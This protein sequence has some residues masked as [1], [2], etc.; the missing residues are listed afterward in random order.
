MEISAGSLCCLSFLLA[1]SATSVDAVGPRNT[2]A[3]RGG[4]ANLTCSN[5][6]YTSPSSGAA[7]WAEGL[8]TFGTQQG[9]IYTGPAFAKYTNF[10]IVSDEFPQMDLTVSDAQ[11]ED[12]GTYTCTMITK[13]GS[14]TLAVEIEG[15]EPII[16][17]DGDSSGNPIKL[18][19][20]EQSVLRCTAS[21]FRPAVNLEWYKDDVQITAGITEDT[22]IANGYAFTTS[23]TLTFTPTKQDDGDRLECRTTGQ[24]VATAKTGGLTLNVQYAPIVNVDFRGGRI[25]CLSDANPLAAS[26]IILNGTDILV[27]FIISGGS[28]EFTPD[29]CNYISCN[30]TN[31]VG[32]GTGTFAK[33]IC[34]ALDAVGPSDT[35]VLRGD[36]ATLTCRNPAYTSPR[37]GAAQWSEGPTPF[38]TQQLGGPYTGSHFA[39]Y[40]HFGIVSVVF[41]QMDLTVSNAQIEDEGTYTCTM[42][43]EQGSATLTV[44]IEGNEPIITLD[45]DSSG[46]PIELTAGEQSALKCTASGFRPAVNLEWYKDDVK[47]TAGVFVHPVADNGDT[48]N[49]SSTLIFTPKIKDDKDRLECRTTGQVVATTKIAVLTLSVQYAPVVKVAYS[50][51]RITCLSD[52]NP[53]AASHQII[54]NGTNI[55][56]SFNNTGGSVEFTPEYCTY[57]SCNS[58]NAVGTRTGTFAK[59]ICPAGT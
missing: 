14:A 6:A 57:I 45:G 46:N 37:S 8:T 44:E 48:F 42:I 30:S 39:K 12:E 33:P 18:T 36:D 29:Y 3:L 35:A 11:V 49:A 5:P 25:T 19:A 38:A 43:T 9:G 16:T 2:A 58:T 20:G 51:G 7:R 22:P 32:T 56:E 10:G 55:V 26:K 1:V 59:P 47:I 23:G 28:V 15:N 27:S 50:G 53:L 31:T 52:A 24:V 41:P 4:A 34:P 17:L 21:G 54:L 13:Q 40:T